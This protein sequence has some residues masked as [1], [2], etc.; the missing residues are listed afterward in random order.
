MLMKTDAKLLEE[1]ET[2][3]FL[4]TPS[5]E[6]LSY[7]LRHRELWPKGFEW[8]FPRCDSCAMGLAIAMWHLTPITRKSRE[9]Y[10]NDWYLAISQ[11]FD[12]DSKTMRMFCS[13]SGYEVSKYTITPEMVADKIDAY[14]AKG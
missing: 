14:L 13:P 6:R 10:Y 2:C 1:I 9:E 4:N 8:D 12:L 11:N 7:L 3:D 5:L